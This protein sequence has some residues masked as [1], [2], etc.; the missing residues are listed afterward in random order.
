MVILAY[1]VYGLNIEKKHIFVFT[2]FT[3]IFLIS[4]IEICK[5]KKTKNKQKKGCVAIATQEDI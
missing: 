3:F 2:T 5:T 4:G 1:M